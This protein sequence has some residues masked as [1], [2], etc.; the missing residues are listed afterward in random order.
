VAVAVAVAGAAADVD[1]S[2]AA[3]QCQRGRCD[4]A[5]AL[6]VGRSI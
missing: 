4:V 6:S 3:E 2:E 5:A 1:A